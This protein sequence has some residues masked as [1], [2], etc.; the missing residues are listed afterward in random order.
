MVFDNFEIFNKHKELWIYMVYRYGILCK[1]REW[2]VIARDYRTFRSKLVGINKAKKN[3]CLENRT[4]NEIKY[5]LFCVVFVCC[6][7]MRKVLKS[8]DL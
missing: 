8:L 7:K 4:K 2:S 6:R 5:E 1:L 3:D